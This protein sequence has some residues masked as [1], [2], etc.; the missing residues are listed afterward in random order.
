MIMPPLHTDPTARVTAP[1]RSRVLTRVAAALAFA[2]PATLAAQVP[3]VPPDSMVAPAPEP[4]RT[5]PESLT[6]NAVIAVVGT[7]P[8]LLSEVEREIASR[9]AR[10][11]MPAP[12][13]AAS[14]AAAIRTVTTELV[15][16]QILVQKAAQMEIVVSD[17]E[18]DRNVEQHIA[19]VTQQF[20]TPEAMAQALASEGLGTMDE[21]RAQIREDFRRQALPERVIARARQ[22][23]LLAPSGVT[24]AEV[25]AALVEFR[26]RLPQKP[27]AVSFR[28]VVISPSATSAAREV[29]RVKA[30]SLHAELRAGGDFEL[31]AR[32]ESMDTG[33]G[34]LGGDL[35]WNRRGKMVPAFDYWMFELPPGRLSPVVE[36]QFGFHIIRVD[37]VQPTERKARHILIS[38][39]VDS[40]DVERAR[41]EAVSVAQQWRSGA[42]FDSLV[43][44]H[45]DAP[46]EK[47][48]NDIRIDQLPPPYS[49]ALGEIP[50]DTI[51]EPFTIDNP[52]G[53]PPKYVVLE[54]VEREFGGQ[55]TEDE[56]RSLVRDQLS[57][58]RTI[59]RYLDRLKSEFHVS[60]MVDE[61]ASARPQDR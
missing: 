3:T 26:D 34:Q 2:L 58:E 43:A 21:F 12:T 8:I 28:Q 35:G 17:D 45:H 53:G 49:A 44:L 14:R 51:L 36:T 5:Q 46:E 48:I 42:A 18:L 40:A 16:S 61:V 54:I 23:G 39:V 4:V 25:E 20:P 15:E 47:L 52:R 60:V 7:T 41:V 55:M 9:V 22:D 24:A 19:Q 29:A 30:E 1:T 27:P 38:P 10:R 32:R 56:A 6:V 50:A 13:D 37:R 33:S 57:Q 59:R 11:M 31:I